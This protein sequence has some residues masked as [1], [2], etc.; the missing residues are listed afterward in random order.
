MKMVFE[1]IED[2]VDVSFA[3]GKM[4]AENNADVQKFLAL[5]SL[6][7]RELIGALCVLADNVVLDVDN[8]YDIDDGYTDDCCACMYADEDYEAD[9]EDVADV[10]DVAT[11][12]EGTSA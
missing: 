3:A 10:A 11:Q 9:A 4:T 5:D 7:Q 2:L 1:T 12:T 8:D 6:Q